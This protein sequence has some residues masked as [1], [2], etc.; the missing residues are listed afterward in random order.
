MYIRS[1]QLH[2]LRH[3]WKAVLA[4]AVLAWA[5]YAYMQPTREADLEAVSGEV[6]RITYRHSGKGSRQVSQ[7][8]TLAVARGTTRI[9]SVPRFDGGRRNGAGVDVAVG[10]LLHVRVSTYDNVYEVRHGRRI[11]LDYARAR[12]AYLQ[13][14]LIPGFLATFFTL[15]GL[16]LAL[17]TWAWPQLRTALR[18]AD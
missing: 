13:H 17:L 3:A 8:L 15:L 9:V 16:V 18:L 11:L 12:Q 7:S 14:L 1:T 6:T 4:A 2:L 5:V 10:D